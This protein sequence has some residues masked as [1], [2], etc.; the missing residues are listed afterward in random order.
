V[1]VLDP[2][3]LG[4]G[5]AGV[6]RQAAGPGGAV[7]PLLAAGDEL[8]DV[9]LVAGVPQD[10]VVGESNTRCRAR[11]SSTTPRLDPRWPP[12]RATVS[13]TMNSRISWAS[14]AS[15]HSSSERR[16]AGDVIESN[17]IGA[18]WP[19]AAADRRPRY[20][21]VV[22]LPDRCDSR[23][24]G[25]P[26]RAKVT[27]DPRPRPV[28]PVRWP[29]GTGGAGTVGERAGPCGRRECGGVHPPLGVGAAR[30][31]H[32]QRPGVGRPG[33]RG[34]TH[35]P[36]L[37]RRPH[38]SALSHRPTG[39]D[40]GAVPRTHLRTASVGPG[41]GGAQRPPGPLAGRGP[42]P[43]RMPSPWRSR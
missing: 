14:S 16:S 41:V 29:G 36:H 22:G 43:T 12:L 8:V 7:E 2:V 38:G 24:D 42:R 15:C 3:V 20:P 34:R 10:A 28:R 1:A 6:A 35:R 18:G 23:S 9:G 33:R 31:P 32:P 25:G 27:A 37:A 13:T 21:S 5:A 11:V 17:S 40:G 19:A 4:L 39:R 26:A 30:R